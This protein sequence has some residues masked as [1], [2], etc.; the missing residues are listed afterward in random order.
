MQSSPPDVSSTG[1]DVV[2]LRE[3]PP[4]APPPPARRRRVAVPLAILLLVIGFIAGRTV[5]PALPPS[6]TGAAPEPAAPPRL[7]DPPSGSDEPVAAVAA[8]VGPAVV[9][10]EAADGLGSGVIYDP[11]G[12]ILTAAHVVEGSPTVGVRLADGTL[13]RGT[14]VGF[15]SG[16]D[17]AVVQ[18]EAVS[19]LPRAVLAIGSD[20]LPGQLAVALGSPFG[21]A[22]TVTAGIV[23][24][25]NRP[26]RGVPMVQTDAAINPG[27]SGGP[28]LD[29]R[30]RVVGINDLIF[31][32]GG[33]NDGVGFAVSIEVAKVVADQIVAGGPVRLARLGVGT[34][35]SMAGEPGAVVDTVF[36]GSAADTAGIVPGDRIVAVD[37][38]GVTSGADLRARILSHVPGA[39]V[40]LVVVRDDVML[41]LAVTL[42]ADG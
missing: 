37:G 42:G 7:V 11:S 35:A 16:T 9:Q 2:A 34:A 1:A 39:S 17:I 31:S 24:A 36:E 5:S 23:S 29:R 8:V 15:H 10:L 28:L 33:G 13:H 22:R 32:E 19:D 40:D 3:P 21:F 20:P 12:L 27:N 14:V 26:V 18:V 4:P 6:V 25:V 30:G 38:R 41:V